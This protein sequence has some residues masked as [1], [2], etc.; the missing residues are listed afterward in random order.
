[1]KIF[2]CCSKHIYNKIPKIKALLESQ[3]HIITLPNSFDAPM[4]E[5]EVK[6]EGDELH[7]EWKSNM[8]RRQEQKVRENDAI[9]VLNMEKKKIPNYIGGATFLEMFQAWRLEK[10]IFLYNPIPEGMLKDEICAFRPKI[11]NQDLRQIV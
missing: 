6:K 8:I 1:M 3:G 11:I 7:A 5:E 4:K 9:L 10:K 2:I